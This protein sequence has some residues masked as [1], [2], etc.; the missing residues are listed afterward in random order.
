MAVNIFVIAAICGNFWGESGVNPGIWEGLVVGNPGY[1]LG[2]WTDVPTAGLYRRTAL[3]NWLSANGYSQDDGWGQLAYLEYE[4]YWVPNGTYGSLFLNLQDYLSYVPGTASNAEIE[5]LT[6][7]WNQAWE[8]IPISSQR[9]TYAL[10]VLDYIVQHIN[11]TRDPWYYGNYYLSETERYKNCLLIYDYFNGY[12]PPTPPTPTP[13]PD[14]ALMAILGKK[15]K[16]RRKL[17]DAV[18]KRRRS[19]LL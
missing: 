13:I 6:Y 14:E 15:L 2:Q 5:T 10:N 9:Y 1:G 16:Q 3:F 4:N 8:G 18:S 17:N 12:I 7:A 19:N 11:D